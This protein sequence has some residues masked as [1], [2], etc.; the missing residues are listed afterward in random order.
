MKERKKEATPSAF[1][2]VYVPNVVSV[3]LHGDLEPCFFFTSADLGIFKGSEEKRRGE[4][5][6]VSSEVPDTRKRL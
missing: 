6:A 3:F 2:F 5:K 4:E 1:V